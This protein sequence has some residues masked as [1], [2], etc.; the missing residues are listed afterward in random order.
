M[1][2][3][4][5]VLFLNI[6]LSA[7]YFDTSTDTDLLQSILAL[8]RNDSSKTPRDTPSSFRAQLPTRHRPVGVFLRAVLDLDTQRAKVCCRVVYGVCESRSTG[9]TAQVML[10]VARDHECRTYPQVRPSPSAGAR[11]GCTV[12]ISS[13]TPDDRCQQR[14]SG[15][16][17]WRSCP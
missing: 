5:T 17:R 7:V 14:W 11:L 16:W 12:S 15:R 9:S 2:L 1:Q 3:Y 6:K 10:V 13:W 8:Q 4:R